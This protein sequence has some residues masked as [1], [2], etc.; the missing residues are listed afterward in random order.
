MEKNC[1]KSAI[2]ARECRS[3]FRLPINGPRTWI[4]SSFIILHRSLLTEIP[5]YH[6]LNISSL[7][8]RQFQ[9]IISETFSHLTI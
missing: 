7:N 6:S 2:K 4:C 8:L 3:Q 1:L 9:I 5:E